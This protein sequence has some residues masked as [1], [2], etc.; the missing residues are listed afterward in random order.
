MNTS[1]TFRTLKAVIFLAFPLTSGAF[2]QNRNCKTELSQSEAWVGE[3]LQLT[4]TIYSPGPFSGTASFDFP[5]IEN[6]VIIRKGNPVLGNETIEGESYLSQRHNFLLIC[7]QA[8]DF[9]L[10]SLEVRFFGKPDFV[11]DPI[12]QVTA[13]EP[14]QCRFV[15][16]VGMENNEIIV[17]AS[18][19]KVD[20]TWSPS[21]PVELKPGDI[22]GRTLTQTIQG[23]T[24]IFLADIL[25]PNI[26]G[27]RVYSES[28]EVFDKVDRG[29]L[30]GTRTDN[31]KYQF[32]RAG[33]F[34]LPDIQL[35]WWNLE[36]ERLETEVLE[37]LRVTVLGDQSAPGI[38]SS[39]QSSEDTDYFYSIIV[40]LFGIALLTGGAIYWCRRPQPPITCAS[41]IRNACLQNDALSTYQA[42]LD[43]KRN[44]GV[45]AELSEK[46]QCCWSELSNVLYA[47]DRSPESWNGQ[48]FLTAFED[49]RSISREAEAKSRLETLPPLN[50]E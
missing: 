29:I 14:I 26:D 43:W 24:S 34:Q 35:R 47:Q 49:N 28:P 45:T 38:S 44:E 7:Q 1:R 20:E 25:T 11:S 50:P 19:L 48:A 21:D 17:S 22:V 30:K 31:V 18:N 15:V 46:L 33:E 37:G 2:A 16:P 32:Q 39:S 3:P 5:Q 42:F 41:R 6:T 9:E 10:P 40:S 13:T 36:N 4:I 23:S 8:G 12:E 27:V